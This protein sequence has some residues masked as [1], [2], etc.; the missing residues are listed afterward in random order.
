VRSVHVLLPD[1]VDDPARPSGGNVYDRRVCTELV[2]AGWSVVEHHVP[3]PWPDPL[4]RDVAALAADLEALADKTAVLIDGLVASAATEAVGRHAARLRVVVLVHLPLGVQSTHRRQTERALL[5]QVE[6]VVATSGWARTWLVEHYRLDPRRVVVAVPGADPAEP[7]DGTASGSALLCV[8]AVTPTKGQDLLV[9]ALSEIGDLAWQCACVGSVEV[10]PAFVREV[11]DRADRG[12][13]A[14]RVT[15]DGPVV[16]TALD[17]AYRAADVLVLPSRAESYGMVVTEA[18]A[19]GLPVIATRAGGTAESL[20]TAS[21]GTVPGL[22]VPPDDAAALAVALR[23][24]LGD[25]GLRSRLRAAAADRRLSLPAW[26][27][28]AARIAGA[29]SCG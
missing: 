21:D 5:A 9:A 19:H 18:L 26:P 7:A 24:W 29:L 22:L 2:A 23:T 14:D 6:G 20:G 13:L 12:G 4:A 25:A 1:G 16:G 27:D 17:A 3:G 8:G 10:E 11:S 15:L 28:T